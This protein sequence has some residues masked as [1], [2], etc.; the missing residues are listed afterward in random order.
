MNILLTKLS[1]FKHYVNEGRD[2]ITECGYVIAKLRTPSGCA[3]LL[4][5]ECLIAFTSLD[6][7]QKESGFSTALELI[8]QA[9]HL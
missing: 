2:V 6:K 5:V 1:K 3:E 7:R 4:A 9:E 8:N